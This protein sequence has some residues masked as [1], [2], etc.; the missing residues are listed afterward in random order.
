ML[1]SRRARMPAPA[2]KKASTRRRCPIHLQN[3]ASRRKRTESSFGILEAGPYDIPPVLLIARQAPKSSAA[4]HTR[5][6]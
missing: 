4:P 2:A 5:I 6:T 1:S 3:G